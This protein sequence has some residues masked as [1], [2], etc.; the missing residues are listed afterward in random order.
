MRLKYSKHRMNKAE[1]AVI[2]SNQMGFCES[3]RK[4]NLE[5]REKSEKKGEEFVCV[6]LWGRREK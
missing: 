1:N 5:I 6:C 3:L 2:F 4:L